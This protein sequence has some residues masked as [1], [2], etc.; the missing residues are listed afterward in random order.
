M[1]ITPYLNFPGTC[2]QA[3]KFYAE[4]LGGEIT[5]MQTHGESPMKDMVEPEWRDKVMHATLQTG[6]NT[7]MG[8]DAPLHMQAKPAGFMVAI[9]PANA[10]DAKRIYAAFADGGDVHM[11]L[12]ETFWT[13]LFGMVTDR[14]GTPW[15]ISLD[16]AA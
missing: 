11:E 3:F 16:T 13:P 6:D 10:D 2:A 9:N 4:T 15:M 1:K 12:Q 8:S 7:L 14:F 5:F